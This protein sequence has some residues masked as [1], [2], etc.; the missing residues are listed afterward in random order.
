MGAFVTFRR[1]TLKK[2]LLSGKLLYHT[3]HPLSRAFRYFLIIPTTFFAFDKK[4]ARRAAGVGT[5]TKS[6]VPTGGRKVACKRPAGGRREAGRRP[7]G[8]RWA[9]VWGGGAAARYT[10]SPAKGNSPPPLYAA[11]DFGKC[12][13]I[14]CRIF[15]RASGRLFQPAWPIAWSHRLRTRACRRWCGEEWRTGWNPSEEQRR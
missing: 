2:P 9:F 12:K 10:S 8:G 15:R 14:S 4:A 7:A 11:G 13:R 1:A 6:A 3:F 5:S